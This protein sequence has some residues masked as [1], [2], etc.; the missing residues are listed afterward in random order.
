MLSDGITNAT[1]TA[2]LWRS[3]LRVRIIIEVAPLI[4][5]T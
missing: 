5:R 2:S 3:S 4:C 1:A